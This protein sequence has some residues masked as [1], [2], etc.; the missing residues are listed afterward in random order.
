M[1]SMKRLLDELEH[2]AH[3]VFVATR[4]DGQT[5]TS[6]PLRLTVNGPPTGTCQITPE[7]GVAFVTLF[8]VTCADVVDEDTPLN[9]SLYVDYRSDALQTVTS[10]VFEPFTLESGSEADDYWV[11]ITVTITDPFGA[12]LTVE[13]AVLVFERPTTEQTT[14]NDVTTLGDYVTT[15]GEHDVT[16]TDVFLTTIGDTTTIYEDDVTTAVDPVTTAVDPVTTAVD[17]VTTA[18]DAVTTVGDALTTAD[19]AVTTAGDAVTTAS[20]AVTTASNL[21]VTDG[22]VTTFAATDTSIVDASTVLIEGMPELCSNLSW[23]RILGSNSRIEIH[24]LK[25]VHVHVHVM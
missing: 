7:E 19:G 12:H 6:P 4:E 22:D 23:L 14:E 9:Y 13:L 18:G 24:Q 5:E 15:V 21:V 11:N 20:D 17:P 25:Y 2:Y 10:P 3:D 1:E 8:Q 16:T